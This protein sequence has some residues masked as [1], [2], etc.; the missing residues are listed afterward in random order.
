MSP[1]SKESPL[2][3]EVFCCINYMLPIPTGLS[4]V[5]LQSQISEDRFSGCYKYLFGQTPASHRRSV[6]LRYVETRLQ[7]G[8]DLGDVAEELGYCSTDHFIK[9]YR[10]LRGLAT[11]DND[12]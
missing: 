8:S 6:M 12:H 4:L 11:A 3:M 7:R 2:L 1:T 10:E 9:T 5:I